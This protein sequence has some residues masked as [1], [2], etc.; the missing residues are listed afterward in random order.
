MRIERML[1]CRA[2][3]KVYEELSISDIPR[4]H[5][6]F[7]Y[8]A[9]AG[10]AS[11]PFRLFPMSS[12]SSEG[13]SNVRRY[14]AV[15]PTADTQLV[16]YTIA[17]SAKNGQGL[18]LE[19]RSLDYSSAKWVSRINYRTH[20]NECQQ[21][22]NY[23]DTHFDNHSDITLTQIIPDRSDMIIRGTYRTPY[24]GRHKIHLICMDC[25]LK[26]LDS[27][28]ILMGS[29][30]EASSTSPFIRYWCQS[31][32]IRVPRELSDFF[33]V[34]WD[35][36]QP[37]TNAFIQVSSPQID[38][39]IGETE[40]RFLS[41]ALDPYYEEWL[42]LQRPSLS[43]LD[44]ESSCPL[45]HMPKFS[46]V[47]PLFKTPI[48]LFN[49]MAASVRNQSYANWEL[50]L[51]NASPEDDALTHQVTEVALNDHR[52]RAVTLKDNLGIS[53]NTREGINRA[54]GDYICFLDHDDLIEPD[55]LFQYA[56]A[57]N[58]HPDADMIY[59]DEDVLDES[60][61]H[62]E[63]FFKPDFDIDL[64][65]TKN[66][67]AHM[68]AV[69][70]EL[71]KRLDFSSPEYDGAQDHHITLQAAERARYVCHIPRVLYHWRVCETSSAGKPE[72]KPYANTA[73]LRAVTAHLKRA[74]LSATVIE[75]KFPFTYRVLYDVPAPHPLV[76]I[77]IP[78]CDHAPVLRTCVE[79]ILE[80]TTYD[81]YEL[82]IVENNSVEESTFEYYDELVK[83]EPQRVHVEYWPGEF[84]Y[85][86][87]INF[88]VERARGNYLL[89]LNNDTELI[90]DEWLERFVGLCARSDVG[91]AGALL[92]Y[93]DDT[94]Q[95]AGVVA[96]AEAGNHLFKDMPRGNFGYFNLVDCQRQLSAVTAACLMT[97]RDVFYEV[98]GFNEDFAVCY[99]DVDYCLKLRD[100]GYHIIYTPEVEMYHHESLS[101]G[102]DTFGTKRVR[103]AGEHALLYRRWHRFYATGD[104][105]FSINVRQEFPLN[106]WYC[107]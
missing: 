45:P 22:R 77:I 74:G 60:G 27:H 71:L 2:S 89:L 100:K 101:R 68:L 21:I 91:A 17:E 107:F 43:E 82:I 85:S 34:G 11:V 102:V 57:I 70:T 56:Q 9:N 38:S 73:G 98:G 15:F 28:F 1:L 12:P 48:N 63:A 49:E 37:G 36:S 14:V 95:H 61:R 58:S 92:Y 3:G 42:T 105:Y 19:Q 50:I 23:D 79:S 66:Y 44:L 80:K 32:S 35:D 6:V 99:N 7:P 16:T 29:S 103:A 72:N 55:A 4:D 41:A 39:L 26:P 10:E 94:I 53:L 47:V 62:R 51:V 67:I 54:T 86:K 25:H 83:R 20:A 93:P 30:Q 81:N 52:I 84:N 33:V 88:G 106:S 87:I 24:V 90:T 8:L 75:G 76:S 104:P 97:T 78:T 31:F 64:L 13:Q 59:C 65:R 18:S 69:R 96:T 5:I 40:R 46:L